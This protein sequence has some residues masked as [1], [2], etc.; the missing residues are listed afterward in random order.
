MAIAIATHA[1]QI[2]AP[3]KTA[4]YYTGFAKINLI[5]LSEASITIGLPS[6]EI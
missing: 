6:C 2:Q 4:N 5:A 1:K 3:Y